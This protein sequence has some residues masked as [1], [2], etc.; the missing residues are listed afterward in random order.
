MLR[1]HQQDGQWRQTLKTLKT[2]G[3]G[4]GG[5]GDGNT[6]NTQFLVVHHKNKKNKKKE[7]KSPHSQEPGGLCWITT[8]R[9]QDF[10]VWG[11]DYWGMNT[12]PLRRPKVSAVADIHNR[13]I[14][15][16]KQLNWCGT[17]GLL[18]L[19]KARGGWWAGPTSAAALV[20]HI[21]TGSCNR[22]TWCLS[23]HRPEWPITMDYWFMNSNHGREHSISTLK[24]DFWLIVFL[25]L[26]G[27]KRL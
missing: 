6:K 4:R 3:G 19:E 9:Q 27:E 25:I 7:N 18:Q 23:A 26:F 13:N 20:P 2:D 22:K 11:R 12:N 24:S 1:N 21:P 16:H 5:G 8:S 15:Q 17:A 14:S 10:C